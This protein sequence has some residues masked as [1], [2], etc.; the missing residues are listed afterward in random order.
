[1]KDNITD[2]VILS[3]VEF[4]KICLEKKE[5]PCFY[6]NWEEISKFF[7]NQTNNFPH[8]FDN[9]RFDTNGHY[10]KSD[11]LEENFSELTACKLLYTIAPQEKVYLASKNLDDGKKEKNK[12]IIRIAQEFYNLFKCSQEGK[13]G[14]HT[15]F[16][17]LEN[18]L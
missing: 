8:L 11:R 10:P 3:I 18:L 7:F 13:L 2:P 15:S 4:T 16:N 17:L 5:M 9:M 1:M 14:E 12:K 6:A